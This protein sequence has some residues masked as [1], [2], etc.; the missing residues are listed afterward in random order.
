ME[1]AKTGGLQKEIE[2]YRKRLQDILASD[3]AKVG[4]LRDSVRS[5]PELDALVRPFFERYVREAHS[6]DGR[7][8]PLAILGSC[9]FAGAAS[10]RIWQALE[11]ELFENDLFLLLS[12]GK[13]LGF[14]DDSALDLAGLPAGTP[15][16]DR[17]AAC[18]KGSWS[19]LALA[20]WS[21]TAKGEQPEKAM[22]FLQATAQVMFVLGQAVVLEM[23]GGA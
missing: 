17:F 8:D 4:L 16:G 11:E 6:A 12:R 13:G 10:V 15:V 5:I 18:V 7:I 19:I 2:T 9:C 21:G 22:L 14:L 1:E 3:A 20:T 23:T